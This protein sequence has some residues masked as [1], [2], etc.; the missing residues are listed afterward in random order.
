MSTQELEKINK[1]LSN[2][3]RVECI[4][5]N[6]RSYVNWNKSNKVTI[7]LQDDGRTMKIFISNDNG[8]K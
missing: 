4:D 7:S 6:G 8:S 5:E 1:Q 2:C 3:T